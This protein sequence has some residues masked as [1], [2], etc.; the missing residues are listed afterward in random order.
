MLCET[1]LELFSQK[2]VWDVYG[3]KTKT[4]ALWSF[5]VTSKCSGPYAVAPIRIETGRYVRSFITMFIM[6]L[7]YCT[8]QYSSFNI[9]KTRLSQGAPLVNPYTGESRAAPGKT[10]AARAISTT[11]FN[12]TN[13][14]FP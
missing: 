8:V 6:I 11:P 3:L 13:I 5:L 10:S 7:P 14:L 1:D 9:S 4:R 2:L 12:C